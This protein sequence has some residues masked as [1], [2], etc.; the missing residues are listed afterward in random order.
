MLPPRE[1]CDVFF[2]KI[3]SIGWRHHGA[4]GRAYSIGGYRTEKQQEYGG[5]HED[6]R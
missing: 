6:N 3:L 5:T 4:S 1:D 2:F